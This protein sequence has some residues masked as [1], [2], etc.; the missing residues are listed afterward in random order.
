MRRQLRHVLLINKLYESRGGAYEI[1]SF[2]EEKN[3]QKNTS[4][5]KQKNLQKLEG[6]HFEFFGTEVFL[7]ACF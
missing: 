1:Y 4:I 2:K 7:F 3:L 5:K 6:D